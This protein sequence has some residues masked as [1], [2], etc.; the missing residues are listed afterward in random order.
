M[1]D[2]SSSQTITHFS[3]TEIAFASRSNFELRKMYWLFSLM[4]DP[5]WNARAIGLLQTALKWRLPV[6]FAIKASIFGHFCGGESVKDCEATI[7][8]LSAFSIGTILD[9]S[10][11]GEKTD[12]GFDA[13]MQEIIRTIDKAKGNSAIP[14][15]VFKVT[16]IAPFAL[17]E[18]ITAGHRLN[19]AEQQALQRVN[20]R[21][22]AICSKAAAHKVRLFFDAEESWIQGAIDEFAYRMMAQYNR[23]ECIIFNTYQLYRWD[24]LPQ[25]QQAVFNAA[26]EGYKL[27][28]K[29]VRGAYM[30]KE[31]AYAVKHRKANPIQPDK[32]STDADFNSAILF[33]LDHLDM[34]SFCAGTHNEESTLLLVQEMEKRGIAHNDPRI[35]FAQLYGMSDNISYKLAAAGY[36]VA[37]YVPYGPVTK[38]MPYLV[39][40]AEEN[41]S[42]AGQTGRELMLI[43]KEMKRRGLL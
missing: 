6:S 33:C 43:K 13:V 12:K 22:E 34:V 20:E 2:H 7:K 39:R 8:K 15:T 17:L 31:A 4:N 18:K 21:I 36:N 30:E 3:D 37:K 19:Q 5:V 23:N 41:T 24:V 25:L 16:G 10:V 27:G 35:W 42:I 32:A 29:L 9:Y 14:F 40:R 1:V 28:A 26:I 38:V 11:E